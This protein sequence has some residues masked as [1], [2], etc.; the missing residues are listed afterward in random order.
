MWPITWPD[1]ANIEGVDPSVKRVCE[2]YASACMTALTLH[3]V[4]GNPVTIMPGGK[5]RIPGHYV[6]FEALPD[7]YPVG[8]FYP[9]LVYP[10]AQDLQAIHTVTE[11]EAVS[12][13]GPVGTIVEVRINGIVLDAASYRIEDGKYLVRLDG[14][15]WPHSSGDNFTVTYHN[16]HPVG[17]LGAH[18]AGVM[19]WEWLKLITRN[20]KDK[21]KLPS[22]AT[23]VNRAGITVEVA[24]GMFPEN[25]TGL[26]EIDAYLLLWNPHQLRV[27]PRVYSPDLP[28]HRQVWHA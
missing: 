3:R 20:A 1:A 11:V 14:Q 9:G 6:W 12:L 26:P 7:E 8:M 15:G 5:D 19:A 21:C 2:L 18:A 27:A 28:R 17:E 4:G 23:N 25:V 10:S 22:T 24:A 13:P 16:S